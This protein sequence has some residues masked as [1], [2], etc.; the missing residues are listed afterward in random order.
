MVWAIVAGTAGATYAKAGAQLLIAPDGRYAGLLSG[1]CLEG[2]LAEHA[3][4]VL[5]SGSARVVS[6]D[7]R[8]PDD[9]LFGLGSGC[10]GAMD[11]LLMRLDADRDWQPLTGLAA[12]WHARQSE[13]LMLVTNSGNPRLPAGAG[14]FPRGSR[15]FGGNLTAAEMAAIHRA[16]NGSANEDGSR[17]L[18]GILPGIEMLWLSQAAP[19][20]VLVLGAGPDAQ[21]VVTL[22]AQLGWSVTVVDHRS[23]YVQAERF[24]GATAVLN[25]GPDSTGAMLN[26]KRPFS[27]AVVMSH[28]FTSDLAYLRALARSE[29]PYIGLLGPV[30]RRERLLSALGPEA[31]RLENRLHAPVGLDLGADTPEAIALAIV[32]EIHA[33]LAGRRPTGPATTW[34]S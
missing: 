9:L 7:M 22:A 6:Y 19:V 13:E 20:P 5:R 4:E 24:P 8:T 3:K 14:V 17:L 15:T 21:P 23:H 34:I 33:V 30:V 32:A 18:T 2:D 27:A 16:M 25:G 26:G 29:V 28:H 12:A 1:G 10:E 31:S 11:I